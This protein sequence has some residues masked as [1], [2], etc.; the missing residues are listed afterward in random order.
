L[1]HAPEIELIF[2]GDEHRHRFDVKV[3]LF[4]Q[5]VQ[6]LIAL[7]AEHNR[8]EQIIQ[9]LLNKVNPVSHTQI[10]PL[11]IKPVLQI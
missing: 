3:K 5:L 10:N 9:V 7:H 11:S 4:K 2:L 1:T 8:T 6:L